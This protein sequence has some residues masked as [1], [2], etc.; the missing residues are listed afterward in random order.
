[1]VPDLA[2]N[3]EILFKEKYIYRFY[4]VQHPINGNYLNDI[5]EKVNGFLLLQSIAN[6]NGKRPIVALENKYLIDKVKSE[7]EVPVVIGY[8]IRNAEHVSQAVL[9]GAD[10]VLVGTAMVEYITQ[11]DYGLFSKFIQ[12]LKEAT[13][14]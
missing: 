2:S 12:N 13:L 1:M 5:K 4:F 7:V 8:G 6:E 14:I 9:C 3:S 11:G 10:G